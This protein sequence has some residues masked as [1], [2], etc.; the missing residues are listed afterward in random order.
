MKKITPNLV[1]LF[2]TQFFGAFNDNLFKSALAIIITY[3]SISLFGVPPASMVALCG[4]IFIL[5]FFFASATA[6]DIS[7]K[8]DKIWLCHKIKEAEVV[9][10]ILG[11]IALALENYYMMLFVLFLLGLQST[12]F[13]PIKYSL[14]PDF[15]HKENLVYS[16]ALISSGSFVAILLGTIIGGLSVA[17]NFN[18]LPL[19]VLIVLVSVFGLVAA[20]RLKIDQVQMD[21]QV[22]EKINWNF[23]SSTSAILKMTFKDPKI[24]ILILGLSW[25]WFLGAG[26]LTLMPTLAKDVLG[27]DESVATLMLFIFTIGMGVGPFVFEKIS[28]GVV[29]NKFIPFS[30]LYMTCAIFLLANEIYRIPKVTGTETL[31]GISDFIGKSYSIG[32]GLHLFLLSFAGGIFTVTQFARL[33]SIT[34][35]DEL[36]RIVAGNN[37]VNSLAMVLVS[38]MLM[39]LFAFKLEL[40]QIFGIFGILNLLVTFALFLNYV[41]KK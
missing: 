10:A 9:I 25:F 29:K 21:E 4:G 38:V 14:I 12:Y 13:G 2:W 18:N 7:D 37:I 34:K 39:A 22:K 40:W 23:F 19:M 8:Y 30:L 31:S 5:P 16:N 28:K 32:V 15:S 41:E 26:L 33:Q 6:G 17:G 36:S 1:S 24:N 11:V 27:A 20:K 3:K 35:Q